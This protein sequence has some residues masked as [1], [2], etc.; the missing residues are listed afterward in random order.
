MSKKCKITP[1]LIERLKENSKL[2]F[3]YSALSTSLGIAEDTFYL[4]I[5]KGRDE[6]L[7]PYC[8]FYATLKESESELLKEC[9]D[10]IKLS[11]KLGNVESTKWLME[12]RFQKDGYGKQSQVNVK[13]HNENL[14]LSINAT[15]TGAEN[16]KIRMAI[17]L[18]LQPKGKFANY[19]EE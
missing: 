12:K 4:W 7:Q 15:A 3:T 2:G 13:S 14:N 17:L 16:E 1:E 19:L 8:S 5:R 6:G 9:L 11:S 18:K 10:Q